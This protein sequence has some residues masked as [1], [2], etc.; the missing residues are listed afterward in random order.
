MWIKI[1]L[2]FLIFSKKFVKIRQAL[3]VPP[4]NPSWPPAAGDSAP[5][6]PLSCD[7]THTYCTATKRFKLVALFNE[8]FK[9]K[10]LVKT[11]CLENTLLEI[12][13]FEHS[14]RFSPPQAVLFYLG[15]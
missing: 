10:I 1:C 6:P 9:E 15:L 11:F 8:D 3:E 14:G 12:F 13:C 4:L 5:K 7:L 2:K